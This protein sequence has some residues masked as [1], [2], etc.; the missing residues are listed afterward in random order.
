MHGNSPE[1]QSQIDEAKVI[2]WDTIQSRVAVKVWTGSKA[3]EIR[4]KCGHRFI[5]GRFVVTNKTDE[6]GTRVKA[7]WCLQGQNDP[8]FHEKIMSGECHSPTLHRLSRALLLQILVSKK[9][10]LNLGDIKGA[11]LEAGPIPEKYRPLYASH[12]AGGIPGVNPDDVI[13]ITGNL[14]GA[15]DAPWQWYKEFHQRACEAGFQ[16]SAFDPCLYYFRN[17]R[18]ELSGVLGA[19]VRRCRHRWGGC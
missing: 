5:G 3:Q 4:Q 18:D 12:P 17:S 1:L 7:R 9:W 13:E 2:E 10:V 8:D 16:R 19:H 6:E 11:F 14:Y 15:T